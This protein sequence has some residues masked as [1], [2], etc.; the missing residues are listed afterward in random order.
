MRNKKYKQIIT[1]TI[2]IA[3]SPATACA[4]GWLSQLWKNSKEN[5]AV[6]GIGALAATSSYLGYKWWQADK[7]AKAEKEKNRKLQQQ[8]DDG[9]ITQKLTAE[10]EKNRTLQKQLDENAAVITH[11]S[12]ELGIALEKERKTNTELIE[13]NKR[14][15]NIFKRSN[16][17]HNTMAQRLRSYYDAEC[18]EHEKTKQ[19]LANYIPKSNS[20]QTNYQ[21]MLQSIKFAAELDLWKKRHAQERQN[22][23]LAQMNVEESQQRAHSIKTQ[24]I[25]TQRNH[26]NTIQTLQ[27]KTQQLEETQRKLIDAQ[28]KNIER[29]HKI[30]TREQGQQ[31]E[32]A[33]TDS[34][35]SLESYSS[36]AGNTPSPQSSPSSL[37]SNSRTPSPTALINE[38]TQ[39]NAIARES[40]EQKEDQE[41]INSKLRF[42]DILNPQSYTTGRKQRPY[43]SLKSDINSLEIQIA[44]LSKEKKF[45][46]EAESELNDLAQRGTQLKDEIAFVLE[47]Y[48]PYSQLKK[49]YINNFIGTELKETE[50]T[51]CF[52]VY[53]YLE[54]DKNDADKVSAQQLSNYIH[55][56]LIPNLKHG[57]EDKDL[58]SETLVKIKTLRQILWVFRNEMTKEVYDACINGEQALQ[59]LQNKETVCNAPNLLLYA[60]THTHHTPFLIPV[61]EEMVIQLNAQLQQTRIKIE[62]LIDTL[63][64]NR[65][66]E[67]KKDKEEY[68][69]L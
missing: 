56:T 59:R 43:S 14:L 23:E 10:K 35:D 13:K 25:G 7:K 61:T 3:M 33:R 42:L 1:L 53:Q 63:K 20:L 69:F 47:R 32:P 17:Y 34:L 49:T 18:I 30:E 21:I 64:T 4:E 28:Q 37:N 5:A 26:Q 54:L 55:T 11:V 44:E 19:K 27:V 39:N 8:I 2:A 12:S 50:K 9:E 31:T 40:K 65:K 22:R 68:D 60:S 15:Q 58:D 66:K 36:T 57:K 52:Q 51:N 48:A 67:E 6:I 62:D 41:K 29:K 24:L 46:Q 45:D 16:K 38:L